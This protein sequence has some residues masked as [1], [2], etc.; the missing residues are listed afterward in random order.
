MAIFEVTREA[1]RPEYRLTVRAAGRDWMQWHCYVWGQDLAVLR[2][3][4]ADGIDGEEVVQPHDWTADALPDEALADR[5]APVWR[6]HADPACAGGWVLGVGQPAC[7]LLVRLAPGQAEQLHDEIDAALD[8]W[9]GYD[10]AE[11]AGR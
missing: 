11:G 8:K 4:L 6:L 1:E 7:G 3:M 10:A 2:D 5:M 9:G